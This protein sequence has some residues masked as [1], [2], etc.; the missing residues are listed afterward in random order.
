MQ[1]LLTFILKCGVLLFHSKV[2]TSD[3][4]SWTIEVSKRYRGTLRTADSEEGLELIDLG[5]MG[6]EEDL[7]LILLGITG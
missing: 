4:L 7:G 5:R 3:C 6:L 1:P 2:N